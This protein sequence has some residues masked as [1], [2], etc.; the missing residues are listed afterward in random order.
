MRLLY[1]EQLAGPYYD[2][3][4]HTVLIGF[5]F[6]MIFGHAPIILP[7]VLR[8]TMIY[9]S[10]LYVPLALLHAG[11]VLR[12][13]GDLTLNLPLR[14]WGGMLNVVAILLYFGMIAASVLM[15][16]RRQSVPVVA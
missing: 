9:W 1:G 15:A 5:A 3:E 12:V 2:A 16:R 11:L 4:L 8:V 13:A 14:A 6:S 7:A 10:A